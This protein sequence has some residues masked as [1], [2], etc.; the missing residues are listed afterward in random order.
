MVGAG[1]R[2][3]VVRKMKYLARMSLAV[4]LIG[5]VTLVA[6]E[7][8][9]QAAASTH[10][11]CGTWRIVRSPAIPDGRLSDV[12]GAS[13]TDVW[14]VGDNSGNNPI[15]EHWDGS[16]WTGKL[17]TSIDGVL[18]TVHAVSADDVWVAGYLYNRGNPKPLVEHWDGGG[19]SIVPVP[20]PGSYRYA[21]EMTGVSPD[22]IWI[23]GSY[24]TR[25]G[26]V[27]PLFLHWN[28]V[29]W[30]HLPQPALPYGGVL[31]GVD[32]ISS[33]DVW[34][35]GYQ[36]S[37]EIFDDQP[38]IEHWD[39]QSWSVV[40]AAPPPSGDG[41]ILRDVSA[42]AADDVWAVGEYETEAQG[43]S[44]PL[45]EHWDGISWNL[46]ESRAPAFSALL[47][48]DALR[49]DAVW[50]VGGTWNQDLAAKVLAENWGGARWAVDRTP[51]PGYSSALEGVAAISE[52]DIWGVGS[53]ID[54]SQDRTPMIMRSRGA[55][56]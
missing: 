50:A 32:A 56:A 22:D 43:V 5:A 18:Y 16:R 34:A 3:G 35:V 44:A 23:V 37:P 54:Q 49:S 28:G 31:L 14:A 55:C 40:P 13:A 46:V 10:G 41:N 2:V 30:R 24:H 39:G 53:V 15:I 7:A 20:V 11:S 17:Q 21:Y 42:V 9:R 8:G 47:A 48:V 45:I 26:T 52:D 6:T 36:G 1:N 12:S 29:R 25:E 27:D 51:S 4:A 19:W 33:N 38:L